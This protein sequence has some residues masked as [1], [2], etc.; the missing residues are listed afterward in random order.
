MV[1]EQEELY[2]DKTFEIA[3]NHSIIILNPNP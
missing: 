1:I 2:L 3:L